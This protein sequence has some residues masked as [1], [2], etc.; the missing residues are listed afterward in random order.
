[1][2]SWAGARPTKGLQLWG[3]GRTLRRRRVPA[4]CLPSF[5]C[6]P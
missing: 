5:Q 2:A 3:E 1:M 6:L 4:K